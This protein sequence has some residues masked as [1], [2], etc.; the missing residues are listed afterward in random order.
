MLNFEKLK[1]RAILTET[2]PYELPTIF[3]NEFLFASEIAL[4]KLA[5][6]LQ[7]I[8]L[9]GEYR[10][11]LKTDSYTVPM[12][13]QV[14]KGANARNT[15]S[16]I[17]PLQQINI[18]NFLEDYGSTIVEACKNSSVSLRAPAEVVPFLAEADRE[19]FFEN[20]EEFEQSSPNDG[21]NGVPYAA[22]FFSLKKYNLLDKF[23][24]SNELLRLETRFPLLRT[25]DV[26]KCFFNIYTHSITWAVKEKAYSKKNSGRYSFEGRFDE[27]LQKSNYNETNGI[28][29]GPEI[30]RVFSEIIFQRI[31]NNII[32]LARKRYDLRLNVDYTFRRYVDD[33]FLF[34]TTDETLARLTRC[35]HDCLEDYKLFANHAKQKDYFRPFITNITLAKKG[36]SQTAVA[37]AEICASELIKNPEN[38]T[39]QVEEREVERRLREISIRFRDVLEELRIVIGE[40]ES[41]FSEVSGPIYTTIIRS[42]TDFSNIVDN[43]SEAFSADI[44]V[45]LRG[46]LRILFYCVASD[47]RAPP[48]FKCHQVLNIARRIGRKAG[49]VTSDV[50]DALIIYEL[51]ELFATYANDES[52]DEI[53]VEICNLF[54]MAATVNSSLFLKQK[55]V[56]DFLEGS[57]EKS[58]FS[59]FSFV[60]ILFLIQNED[61]RYKKIKKHI[62]S[63][64]RERIV[65]HKSSL[66]EDAEVYLLFSDFISCP[67][68]PVRGRTS[69]LNEILSTG[70]QVIN[71]PELL[72][73]APHFAFVDWSGRKSSYI[74]H[75][76]RLQPI[77]YSWYS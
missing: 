5:P 67:Y 27:L 21:L 3:S 71:D 44:S 39:D 6:K 13:F 17:H 15:I 24:N 73:I 65:Q 1:L 72:D 9:E 31:D 57:L 64:T 54:I 19:R 33:F 2:L 45:R 69:L 61:N 68:I 8:F 12:N 56:Q 35:V 40:T 34:A 41:N 70:Q 18:A 60:S 43:D 58:S 62:I 76:K 52:V 4:G 25:I 66:R 20:Q 38:A 75:R 10:R 30:S 42:V 74:L 26:T 28:P 23:Y 22:S 32:K 7:K 55:A 49:E 29:V 36:I 48:L 59:Y 51:S 37:L 11:P 46:I 47:F 63:R 14:R 16:V 50:I 53:P 77:Y